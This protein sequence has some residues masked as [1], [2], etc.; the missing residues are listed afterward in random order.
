MDWAARTG[1]TIL[2]VI[3]V[4]FVWTVLGNVLRIGLAF[5]GVADPDRSRIVAVAVAVVTFVLLL[6]GTVEVRQAAAP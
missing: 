1:D 6:W 3:W 5:G 4:L 2:G